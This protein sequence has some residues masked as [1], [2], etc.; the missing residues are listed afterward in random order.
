MK[1][2]NQY[3]RQLKAVF[4]PVPN[5]S[6]KQVYSQFFRHHEAMGATMLHREDL[7]MPGAPH[8]AHSQFMVDLAQKHAGSQILDV[9]CGTG[10]N[11]IE[12][13]KRGFECTGIEIE[14]Q[15]V[16]QANQHIPA[17][18]MS[19]QSLQFPDKSFDT[20]LMVEVLEHLEDPEKAI[21]EAARVARKNVIL[22][23]PNILPLEVCV[24]YNLIMHHFFDSTHLNF[25]TPSMLERF[26]KSH[27]PKVEIGEFGQ[28]F[29]LSG[30]KLYYHIYAICSF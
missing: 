12:L 8:T 14:S 4:K 10:V 28:F 29:S 11:S 7:Y 19:A 21:S 23:V 1:Q 9:G 24:E 5:I 27:F 18:Q 17:F 16:E 13:K 2:L 15:Y 25:F 6:M 20:I 30:R 3:L 26:L 22:S